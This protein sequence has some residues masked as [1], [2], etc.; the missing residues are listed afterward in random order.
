MGELALEVHAV[1][2]A[3]CGADVKGELRFEVRGMS[4]R[5]ERRLAARD[6][7]ARAKPFGKGAGMLARRDGDESSGDESSEDP[8]A[9]VDAA[10]RRRILQAQMEELRDCSGE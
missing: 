1:C 4:P 8:L 2:A 3:Y 9:G 7:K 6:A 5:R 10:T